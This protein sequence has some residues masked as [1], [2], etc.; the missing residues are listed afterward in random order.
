MSI[1]YMLVG[2]PASGKSTLAKQLGA[3]MNATVL[4]SD[5]LRV[6]LFGDINNQDNNNVLFSELYKRAN[7]L[8][9]EGK[10]V[11]LDSTNINRKRRAHLIKNEIKANEYHVYYMNTHLGECLYRDSN[12]N[13][14]VGYKVIDKMYKNMHIPTKSEGWD[15][16]KFVSNIGVYR[17][18]YK[19]FF[20]ESLEN[21]SHDDLF[22]ELEM[23]VE[24]FRDIRNVPHDS[25][26]H[27]FSISRHT[28]YVY[29]YIVDYYKGNRKKE[30]LVAALFHDI[31]K[32]HCKSFYNYKGEEKRYANYIGHEFV[33]SQ[34]ACSEL[35]ALGYDESFIKYVV[36]MVQ[37]H[38]MSMN[39]SQKVEK[40]L[41]E[42][43][44]EE[45]FNDLMFLHEAD[46][47][48]K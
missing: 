16:V 3:E 9:K 36:D 46:L 34:I 25:S 13:R 15:S 33:S 8:L 42:L 2:L 14:Q 10:N 27:S 19:T 45:Q 29:K 24:E 35:T 26:Y 12:R 7:I 17:S 18:K 38:M 32:G 23:V 21:D 5:E 11:I 37:F 41:K 39:M 22:N 43:L 47:S 4:S 20:E 40:R 48:A 30:M 28:F 44:T 6:E 1:L 31:G